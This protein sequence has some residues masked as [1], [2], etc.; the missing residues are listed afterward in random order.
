MNGQSLSVNQRRSGR[1]NE[2]FAVIDLVP[3][4]EEL[5]VRDARQLLQT[6]PDLT[7]PSSQRQ[8]Q[9]QSDE[10]GGGSEGEIRDPHLNP[11]KARYRSQVSHRFPLLDHE[12]NPFPANL[13][14]FCLPEGARLHR[15]MQLPTYFAFV[16][17][18]ASGQRMFGNCLTFYE[19][20]GEEDMTVIK[21]DLEELGEGVHVLYAPKCLCVLSRWPYF[22]CYRE[23]LSGLYRISLSPSDVPLERFICNFMLEIPNATPGRIEVLYKMQEGGDTISFACPPPN[24]PIAWQALPYE[25]LFQCLDIGNITCVFESLLLERNV[26]LMTKHPYLLTICAEVLTILLYPL[27]WTHVYIPV[28]PEALL[29][30][31]GAP[32]PYLVGVDSSLVEG[33][34]DELVPPHVVVVDLD[35]NQVHMRSA[36][37][38]PQLPSKRRTKLIGALEDCVNFTR[39]HEVP[40]VREAMLSVIDNA[41]RMAARPSEKDDGEPP[42]QG[43]CLRSAWDSVREAFLRLFVALLRGYRRCLVYPTKQDPQHVRGYFS[44][45]A[46]LDNMGEEYRPF[47]AALMSTQAFQN[48]IDARMQPDPDDLDIIFFDE[49]IEAKKNRSRLQ[50]IKKGTEFLLTGTFNK[51]KTIVALAPDTSDLED[52]R[53]RATAS[54]VDRWPSLEEAL[55]SDPRDV[56]GL[57]REEDRSGFAVNMQRRGS[58]ENGLR[59]HRQEEKVGGSVLPLETTV[60]SIFVLGAMAAV[61]REP[62]HN[63][64]GGLGGQLAPSEGMAAEVGRMSDADAAHMFSFA[65]SSMLHGHL[66]RTLMDVLEASGTDSSRPVLADAV[67]ACMQAMHWTRGRRSSSLRLMSFAEGLSDSLPQERPS[68]A[69]PRTSRVEDALD[70]TEASKK[71]FSMAYA[72]LGMMRRSGMMVEEALYRSAISAAGRCGDSERAIE[73]AEMMMESGLMPDTHMGQ[74]LIAAFAND[75]TFD[76]M[77]PLD[78]L[79][80]GK[81][82]ARGTGAVGSSLPKP[83]HM[84][85]VFSRSKS[86]GEGIGDANTGAAAPASGDGKASALRRFISRTSERLS[87]EHKAR[88][89]VGM[90]PNGHQQQ[91]SSSMGRGSIYNFANGFKSLTP[92]TAIHKA[93]QTNSSGISTEAVHHTRVK[94]FDSAVRSSSELQ[95]ACK[96]DDLLLQHIFPGVEID[97][98]SET[99]PKCHHALSCKEIRAGWEPDPNVYTTTCPCGRKFVAHFRVR[100]SDPGWEGST[101]PRTDLWCEFL[102]P[103]VLRK[104]MSTTIQAYGIE[105][106]CSPGFRTSSATSGTIFWNI[107]QQLRMESLPVTWLLAG[108]FADKVVDLLQHPSLPATPP[109]L[110]PRSTAATSSSRTYSGTNASTTA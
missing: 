2:Y 5:Q 50:V 34:L 76:M 88:A 12:D 57:A 19:A 95:A 62:L 8:H 97:T 48:F 70:R 32:M 43:A 81:F 39:Y 47:V 100:V 41:F 74:A 51:V 20:L 31:L 110:P 27:V 92:P 84:S 26:L 59:L 6:K 85:F 99:C 17:T 63:G 87:P 80:W 15:S 55:Y 45:A 102:P 37:Y 24:K 90:P 91:L 33:R 1:L 40:E 25:P 93:F 29:G 73:A 65:A 35:K 22:E 46:F 28:L 77:N 104:E 89:A 4:L 3:G 52:W 54:S 7:L 49:S 68:R 69:L 53:A 42:G 56:P 71:L 30:V 38:L 58:H 60:S 23:W 9:R 105:F 72:V 83:G 44:R 18:Q 101:G 64:K 66:S 96:L 14:L 21:S 82:Q 106:L 98:N 107:V 67:W 75:K 11:L 61:G 103:W 16:H 78:M 36:P 108:T 79:D 109:T 10:S 94:T 86:I 13:P